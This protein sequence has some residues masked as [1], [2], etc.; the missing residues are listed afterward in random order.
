MYIYL[1][2]IVCNAD[3]ENPI[4]EIFTDEH[5]LKAW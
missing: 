2:T 5:F 4:R 3:D 1:D